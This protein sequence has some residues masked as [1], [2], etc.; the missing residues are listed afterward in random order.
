MPVPFWDVEKETQGEHA[1]WD[2][3]MGCVVAMFVGL[4]SSQRRCRGMVLRGPAVLAPGTDS[5]RLGRAGDLPALPERA[6][7]S[8]EDGRGEYPS[9]VC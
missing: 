1:V 2:T 4:G 8:F 7:R 3:A 9:R 6:A 5:G